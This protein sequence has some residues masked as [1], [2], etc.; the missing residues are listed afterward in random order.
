LNPDLNNRT[1]ARPTYRSAILP[2]MFGAGAAKTNAKNTDYVKT[3]SATRA[4][5]PAPVPAAQPVNE[6]WRPLGGR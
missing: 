4:V 2:A 6:G 5:A 1:T 3:A